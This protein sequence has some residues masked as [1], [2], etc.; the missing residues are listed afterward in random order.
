MAKM[1]VLSSAILMLASISAAVAED[2][3]A[4]T[5]ANDVFLKPDGP[6]IGVLNALPDGATVVI[7]KSSGVASIIINH[8]EQ[9][10]LI[11]CD[12]RCHPAPCRAIP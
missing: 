7:R 4:M 11:C 10:N 1:I 5:Q 3:G 8:G 2:S 6:A 12:V 9:V